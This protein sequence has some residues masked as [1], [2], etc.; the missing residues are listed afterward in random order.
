MKKILPFNKKYQGDSIESD[1]V[2]HDPLH[3]IV[4]GGGVLQLPIIKEGLKRKWKII[5]VDQDENSPGKEFASYFLNVST[6]DGHRILELLENKEYTK[7]ISHCITV[8]TDMSMS[9]AIISKK[10]KLTALSC[11]QA[12]VTTHKGKMRE[13][14]KRVGGGVHIQPDFCTSFDKDTLRKYM[15][16]HSAAHPE[17]KNG[18]VIKPV[19]NMGARGVVRLY[20]K[21]DLCFVFELAQ[22]ESIHGE[23]ILEEYIEGKEVSVDAFVYEGKCYLTGVADRI[24][25]QE[26]GLYFIEMGHNMPGNLGE[27]MIEKIR[28]TM[29]SIADSLGSLGDH[30]MSKYHGALKGDLKISAEKNVIVNEFA[31]RLSGGFM[32]T[33]TFPLATK[34]N[35]MSIYLDLIARDKKAFLKGIHSVQNKISKGKGVC[36]ER[37]LV[38][39]QPGRILGLSTPDIS[40]FNHKDAC[41]KHLIFN[42]SKGDILYP[43]RN[44]VGKLGHAI[45]TGS[46][47]RHAEELFHKLS[48]SLKIDVEIPEF[49]EREFSK[50]AKRKFNPKFCWVCRECD[51][52]NC[53]SKVP[54]MGGSGKMNTFRDNIKALE[55]IKLTPNYI[56]RRPKKEGLVRLDSNILGIK[57]SGPLLTAPITGSVSNMGGSISEWDYAYESGMAAKMLGLIPTFGDG[58]TEDKYLIGLKVIQKLGVG[59]PVF[60]PRKSLK[61]IKKRIQEAY[62]H[63][64]KAWGMD[65][66]GLS[67]KTME[68]QNQPTNRKISSEIMELGNCT[69]IPFFIKGVMTILDAK[70]A[71]EAGASAIIV[72]NHG[73]RVLDSMPGTARV[74]PKIVEFIHKNYAGVEILVDGG[75]R[76]GTDIFKMMCLGAKAVLVGRPVVIATIAYQRIGAYHLLRS[77]LNDL[78]KTIKIYGLSG[79]KDIYHNKQ[80]SPIMVTSL[81]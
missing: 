17:K 62:D 16:K 45:I 3:V 18:Y 70:L 7:K 52:N 29:Q 76:S 71:C 19:D 58:A 31:S 38:S 21:D 46:S 81:K 43:L 32:S 78:K 5:V 14:L 6:R 51:G 55:E 61:Q 54:G 64:A 41:V 56:D 66:D 36:I 35:L 74:L 28:H 26:N 53:A 10:L 72:S 34:C 33:H 73:G 48:G 2:H 77:Y 23:V 12:L 8:G 27:E 68:S 4:L 60:K 57:T 59:F 80:S 67:F 47:L 50:E 20:H 24:I 75:I 1:L 63:G 42:H 65:I 30:K 37:A 69:S 44:N 79:I 13:F 9:V 11:E 15:D 39:S 40:E 25:H 49:N 22:R